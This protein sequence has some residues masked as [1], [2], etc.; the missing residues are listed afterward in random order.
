M[1]FYHP[2]DFNQHYIAHHSMYGAV[3]FFPVNSSQVNQP[4]YWNGYSH[5]Y[6]SVPNTNTYQAMTK[7]TVQ[8]PTHPVQQQNRQQQQNQGSNAPFQ[9]PPVDAN[10]LNQSAIETRKLMRE[11]SIILNK[12]ATSKEFGAQLMDSAQRSNMEEVNRLISSIGVHSEV[13][14]RYNPDG[15]ILE[16]VSDLDESECCRLSISLRWR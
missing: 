12:F 11:A 10:L 7:P 1:Y 3:P 14:V 5:P 4:T 13:K 2:S 6:T 8:Q 16:L 15:L 9:Y